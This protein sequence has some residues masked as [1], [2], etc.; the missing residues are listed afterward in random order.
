MWRPG[1]QQSLHYRKVLR[2]WTTWKT[3]GPRWFLYN[4]HTWTGN[5]LLSSSQPPPKNYF[6]TAAILTLTQSRRIPFEGRAPTDSAIRAPGT[7]TCHSSRH[8]RFPRGSFLPLF[9][10]FCQLK[11][12]KRLRALPSSLYKSSAEEDSRHSDILKP[13]FTGV[14]YSRQS[15]KK[16]KKMSASA[17]LFITAWIFPGQR[18]QFRSKSNLASCKKIFKVM[19]LLNRLLNRDVRDWASR[20]ENHVHEMSF[21]TLYPFWQERK[22]RALRGVTVVLNDWG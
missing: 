20:Y 22:R 21:C 13:R 3:I 17:R 6:C 15:F 14:I 11:R 4:V 9:K 12:H 16:K 5:R 1:Y 8:E 18:W 2:H 19:S 7:I 10:P